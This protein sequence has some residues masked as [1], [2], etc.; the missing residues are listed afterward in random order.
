MCTNPFLAHPQPLTEPRSL[1]PHL[2][3][4]PPGC[5]DN[6]LPSLTQRL[7]TA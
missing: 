5:R 7:E 3:L 6:A 1:F 2:F 4:G